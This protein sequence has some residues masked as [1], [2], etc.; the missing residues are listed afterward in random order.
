M[1]WAEVDIPEDT[2][3]DAQSSRDQLFESFVRVTAAGFA[4]ALVGLSRQN[5]SAG[6]TIFKRAVVAS[7]KQ[8]RPPRAVPKL[9][10]V[11][12]AEGGPNIPLMWA[13]SF[14]AFISILETS[15]FWSPATITMNIYQTS[16]H[17]EEI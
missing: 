12:Q 14:M 11:Q 5:Q 16:L 10:T 1:N 13:S 4:G 3:D 7:G 2:N 8:K 9:K 17:L 6:A 15:R